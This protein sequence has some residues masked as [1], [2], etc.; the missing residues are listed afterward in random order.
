MTEKI[1]LEELE[2][3]DVFDPNRYKK[4]ELLKMFI[5]F[6]FFY[7]ILGQQNSSKIMTLSLF[8]I[9]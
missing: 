3:L 7:P 8:K 1:S 4:K 9:R 2:S 6:T 5:L